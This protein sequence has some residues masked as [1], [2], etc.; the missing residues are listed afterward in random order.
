MTRELVTHLVVEAFVPDKSL[1]VL[2]TST[3]ATVSLDSCDKA[4][5]SV[6]R[7]DCAV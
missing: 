6:R 5:P 1:P 2:D 3:A 7:G 4:R